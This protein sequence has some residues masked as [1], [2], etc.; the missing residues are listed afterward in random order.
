M[1]CL[2]RFTTRRSISPSVSST[3]SSAMRDTTTAA[4]QSSINILETSHIDDKFH[5]DFTIIMQRWSNNS[6]TREDWEYLKQCT[7]TDKQF[8]QITE[9]FGLK[10]GVELIDHRIVFMEYP[11][12]V[13]EYRGLHVGRI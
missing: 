4:G 5:Q 1:C 6:I 2:H 3:T 11:T 13:H 9:E 10:H 12:A 7:F 8:V